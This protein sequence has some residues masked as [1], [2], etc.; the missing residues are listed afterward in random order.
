MIPGVEFRRSTALADVRANRASVR[1]GAE[2]APAAPQA[3][4]PGALAWV[5][6]VGIIGVVAVSVYLQATGRL[7][8]SRPYYSPYPYPYYY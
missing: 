2:V 6:V 7:P 4:S 8:P 5:M 3:S 1:T